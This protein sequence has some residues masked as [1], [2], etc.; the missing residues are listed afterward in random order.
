MSMFHDDTIYDVTVFDNQDRDSRQHFVGINFQKKVIPIGTR[1]SVQGKFLRVLENKGSYIPSQ[2]EDLATGQV[3]S[4]PRARWMPRFSITTH[5]PFG[6]GAVP[7]G[8][9]LLEKPRDVSVPVVSVPEVEEPEFDEPMIME[10]DD[11]SGKPMAEVR[12][13][14]AKRGIRYKPTNTKDELIALLASQE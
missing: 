2:V 11:L 7:A 8:G 6:G 4:D 1:T 14:C 13:M 9:V 12:A 5:G 10:D 3:R